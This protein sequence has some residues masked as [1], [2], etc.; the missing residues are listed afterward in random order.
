MVKVDL[1]VFFIFQAEDMVK[2]CLSFTESQPICAYKGV[3]S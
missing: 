1:N 3:I 2:L